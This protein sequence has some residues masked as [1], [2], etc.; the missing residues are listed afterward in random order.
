MEICDFN[1]SYIRFR[2]DT[3]KKQPVTVSQKLPMTLNNV[4]MPLECRAKVTDLRT[5][6]SSEYVLSASCKSEQ[7]WVEKNIWHQ[8][9]ADMC[10]LAAKNQCLIVKQ[11]DRCKKGVMLYP[12]SLGVQPER[13]L[14]DPTE[15]YDRYSIDLAMRLGRELNSISEIIEVL[16]ADR[17]LVSMT[18]YQMGNHRISIEYPVKAVNFSERENYYQ[19]DT[20]PVIFPE[21]SGTHESVIESLQMAYVAHNCSDWAEFVV[22]CPTTLNESISV[23]HYSRPV[24]V[25]GTKNSLIAIV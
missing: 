12:E 6:Q 25:D 16:F 2:M 4:R 11:W 20:G 14:V 22:S 7:V 15:A 24:R 9:N 8:P 17:P 3:Q 13:Q 18:E 21:L 10:I 19:V 1:R 23:H 5:G